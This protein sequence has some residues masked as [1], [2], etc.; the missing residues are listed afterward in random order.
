MKAYR[1]SLRIKSDYASTYHDIGWIYNEQKNYEDAATNLKQAI[2]LNPNFAD[3]H[4]ELGYSLR[5]LGRY[6][7]AIEEYQEAIRLESAGRPRLSW[8]G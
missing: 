6:S 8:F 5:N 3:A 7:E 1:E 4:N 2:K